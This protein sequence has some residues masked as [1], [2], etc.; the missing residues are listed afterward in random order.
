MAGPSYVLDKTHT[1]NQTG[2]VGKYVCVIAD[3]VTDGSVKLPT[4]AKQKIKGVTQEAQ[5]NNGENVVVRKQ[6]I[7]RVQIASAV[8]DGDL[9]E[10]ANTSGQ[11]QTATPSVTGGNVHYAVGTAE[12]SGTT[13]GQI[14]YMSMPALSLPFEGA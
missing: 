2:G 7:T 11:V 14:I 1:V 5:L 8:N 6:G 3:G 9:L 12:S 10:V 13:A 4:A